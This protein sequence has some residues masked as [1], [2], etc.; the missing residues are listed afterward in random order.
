MNDYGKVIIFEPTNKFFSKENAF[1]NNQSIFNK[2]GLLKDLILENKNSFS[3][4]ILL[5][6]FQ[7]AIQLTSPFLTQITFDSGIISKNLDVLITVFIV[8]TIIYIFSSFINYTNGIISNRIA[9][10]I[11]FSFSNNF[12]TKIF[13]IPLW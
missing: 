1:F 12:I 3:L 9:Q 7:L 4:L 6:V 5:L 2:I 8:Q 11:N 10:R 13:K